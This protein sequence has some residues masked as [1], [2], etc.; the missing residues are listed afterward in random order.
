MQLPSYQPIPYEKP[1]ITLQDGQFCPS[2]Q[3][4]YSAYREPTFGHGVLELVNATHARWAWQ[5]TIDVGDGQGAV[6]E[7]WLAKPPAGSCK[8]GRSAAATDGAS[9]A[10][11]APGA[12][13]PAAAPASWPGSGASDGG[14]GMLLLLLLGALAVAAALLQ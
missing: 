9:A 2:S 12:S 1:V 6:D 3:P 8:T 4:A 10:G 7:V 13:A 5:R 11:P 14:H